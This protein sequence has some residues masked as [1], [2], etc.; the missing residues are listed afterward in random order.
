MLAHAEK[1]THPD[2]HK[3][4]EGAELPAEIGRR[5]FLHGLG[6]LLHL[7]GA[8]AGI[9]RWDRSNS[10]VSLRSILLP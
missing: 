7:R 10:Y 1:S 6:D 2:D 4:A 3:D 5:T 9:D 8:L